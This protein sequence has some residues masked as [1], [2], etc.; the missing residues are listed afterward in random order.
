MASRRLPLILAWL[1]VLAA[2]AAALAYAVFAP[3]LGAPPAAE[4]GRNGSEVR[5]SLEEIPTLTE[6]EASTESRL[7]EA[8]ALSPA[9]EAVPAASGSSEDPKI[10]IVL[11]GLGLSQKN[12]T[13]A[14]QAL[15]AQITLS[16]TPYSEDVERWM[17][18]AR[19]AGHEVL[20]DLPMEPASFPSNDP[21]PRAL[22]TSLSPA[23]NR[24][25]LDWILERAHDAVGVTGVMGS[26][27]SRA[28]DQM[29]PVLQALKDRGLLYLD[30][31]E[32]DLGVASTLADQIGLPYAASSRT[33]DESHAS[34]VVVDARLAQIERVALTDGLAVAIGHPFPLTLERLATWSETLAERGFILVP[35]SA[36]TSPR[37]PT[38]GRSD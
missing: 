1:L 21:G 4:G 30:N 8:A 24:A 17:A 28:E 32:S 33:L 23:E 9:E 19:A 31:Q 35:I 10:A 7:P 16:F 11:S 26:R 20:I 34:Q 5:I 18:E 29:L 38:T 13:A 2:M 14:I 12:T 15:P 3:E 22:I 25:R 36:V 6:T 27:F 37:P